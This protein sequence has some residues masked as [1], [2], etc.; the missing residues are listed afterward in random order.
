MFSG[1]AFR[2]KPPKKSNKVVPG[3]NL[4][5]PHENDAEGKLQQASSSSWQVTLESIAHAIDE[6][7]DLNRELRSI[8][9]EGLRAQG[10]VVKVLKEVKD[11][12]RL[13]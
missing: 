13:R 8:F 4:E 6:V 10:D 9:A 7:N 2:S 1:M 11:N 5:Y 12:V 3:D